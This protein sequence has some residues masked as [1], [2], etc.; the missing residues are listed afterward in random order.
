MKN[1]ISIWNALKQFDLSRTPGILIGTDE[2]GRG[3]L[4]GP[5][6]AAAVVLDYHFSL[7]KLNDSKKVTSKTR[8]TLFHQITATAR[9]W[10]IALSSAQEIDQM[11][12]LQ[13]SLK[14]MSHAC[15][16]IMLIPKVVLVDG[17]QLVPDLDAPQQSIVRGDAQSAAIAAASIL[18]K[19]SR[20]HIMN[21]Y[22][23]LYPE[24]GFNQ[25]KGYPTAHH[26]KILCQLGPCPIHRLSFTLNPSSRQPA[27]F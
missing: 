6:V 10:A 9:D 24:Y 5:V 15:K 4:A 3:S 25:H 20:D 21:F 11:N 22:H 26:I 8:L 17:N 1:R 12:I 13:A 18:A 14:A 27:V 23:R 7:D 2:A 19:V 16:R